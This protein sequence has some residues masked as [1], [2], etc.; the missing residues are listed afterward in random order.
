MASNSRISEVEEEKITKI[1]D[2][3]NPKNVFSK[4]KILGH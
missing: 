3:A 1:I 2:A 4:L